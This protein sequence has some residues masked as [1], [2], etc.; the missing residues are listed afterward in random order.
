MQLNWYHEA[1]FVGYYVADAKGF[2]RDGGLDVQ[3]REGGPGKPAI[4]SALDG[5]ADFAISS[6]GE[7][8]DAVV[9]HEPVVAV[10]AGFQIPPLV[11][12]SLVDAGIAR[13][14]DLAGRRV[15][16]TTD[17]WRDVLDQTLRAANVKPASVTKVAVR[18]E[19]LEALYDGKVD[20]WLGYAQDE[21]IKAQVA[22]HP[23]TT[24]F[25]ADYGVGGYEGL[26]LVGDPVTRTR[27]G[28]RAAVRAGEPAG[29]ALRRGTPGRSGWHPAQVGSCRRTRLPEGGGPRGRPLGRHP[30][31]P[32]R[33]DRRAALAGAHG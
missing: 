18:P 26:L 10:M 24:I 4:D 22:G 8:R 3:I 28:P 14:A 13:P 30:A 2:Y 33:L 7:T 17:Y 12:F 6:F 16:V 19:D 11:I 1:E 25:P 31:G 5:S 21:P 27:S 9:K 23:V 15:G 29:V 20:A 32:H